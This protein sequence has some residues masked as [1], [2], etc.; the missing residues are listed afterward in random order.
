MVFFLLDQLEE[1]IEDV[2]ESAGD[3]SEA[4]V[5]VTDAIIDATDPSEVID[6]VA[7]ATFNYA[8]IILAGYL[9]SSLFF[10]MTLSGLS[11][12]E[13]AKKGNWYGVV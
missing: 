1:I 10:I 7:T 3:V 8:N 11:N 6:A 5:D 9:I 13:S 12:Q 4:I 2:T